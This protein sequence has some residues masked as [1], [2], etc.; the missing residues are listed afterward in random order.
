MTETYLLPIRTAALIF[1]ALAFVM[2]VPTAIVLYRRHGVMTR[3]RV[4]SLYGGVFYGLTA[5]CMTIVPLPRRSMDVCKAYPTF[6][7]PQLTPGVAF[8]DI[9]K[10]AHHRVTLDALVLHNPAFWQT[11]FNLILL[12]PLGVFVR[13]HFRRGLAAATAA[14]FAGS[15]FFELTQYTGLWGLYSCPYRLFAVDDLIVNTAGA[16]LGWAL[17]GPLV[18]ALPELDA[19]DGRALAQLAAGRIPFGR[20]LVA[21]LLDV[22]GVVLLTLVAGV[23]AH[24][25][26]GGEGDLLVPPAVLGL[27]FVVI[28]WRTGT[29]PGKRVL[30][31][32]LATPDGERP[33][34]AGL[35]LRALALS[36][37]LALA[38]LAAGGVLAG[39][40]VTLAMPS[41]LTAIA[42]G[43][44][45]YRNV[46]Y[47]L[48]ADPV[49]GLFLLLL[50][51]LFLLLI[52]GYVRAVRRH[53]RGLG[54]HE[55]LSGVRNQALPPTRVRPRPRTP[56][57]PGD[58]PPVATV[59]GPRSEGSDGRPAIARRPE[60]EHA[61]H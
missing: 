50:P 47:R 12:V 34:L 8:S 48:A 21:L 11:V 32:R 17:A 53:P 61:S 57:H 26:T 54:P 18:R 13:T 44:V 45:D 15:L 46:A 29:T 23:V 49:L 37:V 10:E 5:F 1:P 4:L 40:T 25:V 51:V 33:G 22:V 39:G 60:Y 36:P 19:L 3:W 58:S 42:D 2:F 20:R 6:A 55:L 41:V 56:A 31:L 27:W 16:A 14:G 43:A 35:A 52:G 28:P 7:E 38:C 30:L 59:P 9:W 24:V